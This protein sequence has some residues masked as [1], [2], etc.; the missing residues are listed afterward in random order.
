MTD[1]SDDRG[2]LSGRSLL[3]CD[4]AFQNCQ[5]TAKK[6]ASVVLLSPLGGEITP[7]AILEK[8]PADAE[9]V[10]VRIDQNKAYWVK[11]EDYG[12]VDLYVKTMARYV[13]NHTLDLFLRIQLS[14][15][16]KQ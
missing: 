15:L 1:P 16:Q 9:K 5:K 10:Y 12:S 4:Y 13:N 6:V 11:G 7:K 8:V 2:M 14:V 3:I